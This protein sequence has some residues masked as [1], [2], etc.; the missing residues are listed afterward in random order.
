MTDVINV[1]VHDLMSVSTFSISTE[2]LDVPQ[3]RSEQNDDI[4][5]GAERPFPETEMQHEY[6]YNNQESLN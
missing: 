1:L 4:D 5:G 2:P 6:E 3:T